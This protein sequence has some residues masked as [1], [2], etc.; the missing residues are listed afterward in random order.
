MSLKQKIGV[1]GDSVLKGV[2]FD[3]VRG[4]YQLLAQSCVQMVEQVFNT[5]IINRTRFGSTV[6]KGHQQLKKALKAGLD[7]D[8]ILLE[9]GGN[10][11]DFDWSAVSAAPFKDHQPRT[12]MPRF[13]NNL[14]DMVALIRSHGMIPAL[15]SLPPIDGQRYLD[16]LVSKGSDRDALLA[17]LG[18]PQQI[19]YHH[20]WY[21]LAVTRLAQ[22]LACQ[23]VPMREAF[24]ARGKCFELLCM[25]GIHP[26]ESGHHLMQDVFTRYSVE[27]RLIEA[28]KP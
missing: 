10:D 9:Y 1:W 27:K 22:E 28:V 3:D 17:F 13:L 2:V 11:C 14:R 8:I 6:E 24:L 23:Y 15:M 16:Y 5:T 21:S 25:D 7:C 18:Q 12:P 26:N 19:Y 4:T 20:E